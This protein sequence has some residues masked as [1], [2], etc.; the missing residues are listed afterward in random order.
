MSD[1]HAASSHA[2]SQSSLDRDIATQARSETA[3]LRDA[4]A[5]ARDRLADE[6]DAAALERD[7]L[8]ERLDA[9]SA[10]LE[11]EPHDGNGTR[12]RGADILMRAAGLRRRAAAGRARAAEQREAAAR[13]RNQAAQDRRQAARDRAAAAAELAVEGVDHLTGALRRGVGL[14]AMQRELDRT[15]RS[16]EG[17]VMAFVDVVGLKLLNDNEGHAAGDDLLRRVAQAIS[18]HLRRYDLVARYGGDEFVCTLTGLDTDAARERFAQIAR[19]LEA[20]GGRPAELTVGL[21]ER[22]GDELLDD[23]IRR[24]D[25]AMLEARRAPRA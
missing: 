2:Q 20:G 5:T 10:R 6:R 21:A 25:M 3:R 24:A 11:L 9:E 1:A 4:A 17:L 16:G 15:D 18:E 19:R 14:A 22:V 13:D 12:L 8:A 7:R 23:L